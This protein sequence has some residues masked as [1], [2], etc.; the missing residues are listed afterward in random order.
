[1]N[2][3]RKR[4]QDE[5]LA[6]IKDLDP[7]GENIA[8]WQYRFSQMSDKDFDNFMKEMNSNP[9][10]THI[11]V[12]LDQS[13]NKTDEMIDLTHI[14][15]VAKK[16]NIKLREYV[17]FPH[18]NPNDPDNPVVTATPVPILVIYIR[19]MQQFLQH[20]N[21]SV[22]TVEH[23][24]PLTGQVTGD[25]KAASIGDM[26]TAALVTTN[27]QDSLRE[28]LTI[29]ADNLPGKIR[30]L[31][32]IEQTGIVKYEDCGVKLNDSQSLKTARTFLRGA[33]LDSKILNPKTDANLTPQK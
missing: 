25:S 3:K 28:F 2:E 33:F 30:M 22:G 27:Q 4:A 11:S 18:L 7:S 9:E 8:P 12:D 19:K 14:E 1:M 16:Y 6:L 17:A 31:N 32:E 26:Q 13:S 23:S 15:K 10:H 5:I 21:F 20:K 24:N 29:R